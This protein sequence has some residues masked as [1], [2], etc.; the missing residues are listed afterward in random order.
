MPDFGFA[1]YA[2][3]APNVFGQMRYLQAVGACVPEAVQEE[4]A[5]LEPGDDA[6]LRSWASRRGFED[7][8]PISAA[9][10]HCALW[11]D[12]PDTKGKW[13]IVTGSHWEPVMPAFAAWNP[14]VESEP[15][16]R[17]RFE[18]YIEICKAAPAMRKTPEKRT[19][20]A[21]FEWLALHHAGRMTYTQVENWLS[22][23]RQYPDRAEIS[24]A[25]RETAAMI[26]LTLRPA[27]G[28]KVEP[29][30]LNQPQQSH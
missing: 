15:A 18:R 22:E 21:H 6:A 10:E 27:R 20:D 25:I 29:R 9:R 4:L 5:D 14:F 3:A 7:D 19:G 30:S 23:K 16:L 28:R 2:P 11:R 12:N 1:D 13:I 17:E 24:R 26:G 8:W